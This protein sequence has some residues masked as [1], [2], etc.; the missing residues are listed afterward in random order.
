MN[1]IVEL[2]KG[3][4][5]PVQIVAGLVIGLALGFFAPGIEVISFLGTLFT[6][7]LKA[8]API[9]VFFLVV[10]ALCNARGM[11]AAKTVVPMLFIAMLISACVTV[12][13]FFVFPVSI[14]LSGVAADASEDKDLGGIFSDLFLNFFTN[15]VQALGNANY[16]GILAWA[17]AFGIFMR[18]AH[19]FTKKV[20]DD[21]TESML[22]IIKLITAAD[23]LFGWPHL[24]VPRRGR[25]GARPAKP[26]VS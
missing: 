20:L 5:L 13:V 25:G 21:F 15:P 2:Y 18:K 4:S 19:D 24:R 11:G 7:A 26:E 6:T 3:L 1:K 14:T 23:A 17:I 8:A 22:G 9:L 16:L 10:T 12:I